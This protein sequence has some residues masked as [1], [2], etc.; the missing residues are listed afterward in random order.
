MVYMARDGKVRMHFRVA[1]RQYAEG[2]NLNLRRSARG[3][4][5]VDI[6][7]QYGDVLISVENMKYLGNAPNG[8][9]YY[10]AGWMVLSN[11]YK[12]SMGP[13]SIDAKGCGKSYWRF[14][15][16]N[17]AGVGAKRND[18]HGFAMTE[19]V[20][21]ASP[22]P[23]NGY[24][25]LG[26]LDK[27]NNCLQPPTMPSSPEVYPSNPYPHSPATAVWPASLNVGIMGQTPGNVALDP[28]SY[29]PYS[30]CPMGIPGMQDK[31]SFLFGFRASETGL[32]RIAFAFPGVAGQPAM[33]DESGEWRPSGTESPPGYWIYYRD[34][35][36]VA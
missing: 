36:F 3:V 26:C 11:G 35:H 7:E 33:Q 18:I 13:I 9:P 10:Y 16:E 14:N 15:P 17:I 12:I 23:S 25:L 30:W 31:S 5:H 28:I 2:W 6:N 29:L 32:V 27:E 4:A 20:M 1:L 24:V 19:E 34:P 21:D 22:Y 8:L